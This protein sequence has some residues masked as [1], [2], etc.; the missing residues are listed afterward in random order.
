MVVTALIISLVFRTFF[1]QLNPTSAQ[2]P[3][4]KPNLREET[5]NELWELMETLN[6]ALKKYGFDS[7]A[8]MQRIVCAYV[9]NSMRAKESRGKMSHWNKIIEGLSRSDW[10]MD[11]VAGTDI[12]TAIK[13]ARNEDNCKSFYKRCRPAAWFFK[14]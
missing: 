10:A 11:Y 8:C 12:E 9:K 7:G 13:V 4:Q 3:S 14:S 5:E 1:A 6:V 2:P